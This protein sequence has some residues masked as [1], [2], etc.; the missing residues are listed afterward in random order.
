M[1]LERIFGIPLGL[2][3]L[4]DAVVYGGDILLMLGTD[5]YTPLAVKAS[6]IAPEVSWL[7][8]EL[9]TLLAVVAAS[10]YVTNVL[11]NIYERRKERGLTDDE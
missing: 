10:L 4:F 2:G 3:V 9:V 6:W 5:L 7:N 1:T 11:I 8:E